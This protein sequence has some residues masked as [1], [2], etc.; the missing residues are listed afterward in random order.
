M[1]DSLSFWLPFKGTVAVSNL[2]CQIIFNNVREYNSWEDCFDVWLS[3]ILI[4]TI[5]WM[6]Y[7]KFHAYECHIFQNENLLNLIQS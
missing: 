7:S 4:C 2:I 5:L 3:G 6:H 1:Y